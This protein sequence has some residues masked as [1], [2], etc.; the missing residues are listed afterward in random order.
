MKAPLNKLSGYLQIFIGAGAIAGGIQL[1]IVPDGSGM[2][3]STEILSKSPFTNFLI[4]GITLFTV[5]GLGNLLGAWFSLNDKK[6]AGIYGS[7]MG[8]TLISW[9]LI[10][11][12]LIGWGIWLQPFYL[13]IGT[14]ELILG[15]ILFKRMK[16]QNDYRY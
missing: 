2:G 13:A 10:Q 1:I 16:S 3:M 4:P 9:M 12:I 11:I 6:N 8:A 15:F 14:V 7:I 5:I